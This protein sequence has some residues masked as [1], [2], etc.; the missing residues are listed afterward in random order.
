MQCMLEI[1]FNSSIISFECCCYLVQ[2]D[3]YYIDQHKFFSKGLYK[4]MFHPI[5]L[6]KTDGDAG[7]DMENKP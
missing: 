5:L 2:L 1:Y 4:N 6:A 3:A 7:S